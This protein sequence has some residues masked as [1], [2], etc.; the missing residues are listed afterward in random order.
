MPARTG[1]TGLTPYAFKTRTL[2]KRLSSRL[3]RQKVQ[4]KAKQ[5]GV[6]IFGCKTR[7]HATESLNGRVVGTGSM[8]WLQNRIRLP[9][10]QQHDQSYVC[11]TR[12]APESSLGIVLVIAQR[13]VSPLNSSGVLPRLLAATRHLQPH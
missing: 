6:A 13:L 12:D 4:A 3:A 11:V 5:T 8:T 1:G 10:L 2:L 7:R 9:G